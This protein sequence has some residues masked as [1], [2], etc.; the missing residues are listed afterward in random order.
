LHVAWDRERRLEKELFKE[1]IQRTQ[2]RCYF[3]AAGA[4]RWNNPEFDL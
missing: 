3:A 4:E 1:K 2:A